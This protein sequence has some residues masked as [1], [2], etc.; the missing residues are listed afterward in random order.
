MINVKELAKAVKGTITHG[1]LDVNISYVS[2]NSKD[3]EAGALFVP[4]IGQ[5]HDG[6]DFIEDAYKHGALACFS[7]KDEVYNEGIVVIKVADTLKALQ[8]FATY[9]RNKFDI[10]IVGITGSVGKTTTKE[11]IS[12]AL[13]TKYN[14]LK[15]A[16]NMN[17][18]VGLPLMIL[19]IRE[20]HDIGV[21]EMGI[22]EEGEMDRL[23]SIVKPD[24]SVITNIGVSHIGQLKTKENIRR[25]KLC[26]I[27]NSNDSFL[28]IN[29]DDP[30][31]QEVKN[32][33]SSQNF[34][35]IYLSET[36]KSKTKSLKI[37]TYGINGV[38]DY[39]AQNIKVIDDKT[40]FT[41]IDSISGIQEEVVLNVLGEHNISNALCALAIAKHY[42]IPPSIAKKGLEAYKPL[43]MR[44]DIKKGKGLT[45]IDDTYNASPD[46]MKAGIDILLSLDN[47]NRRIAVLADVLELGDISKESHLGV[48]KY[49]SQR[50][51]DELITIGKDA[52]YIAKGVSDN[53]KELITHS[54]DNNI[55][56]INYLS[57]IVKA[58]DALLVKGSRGMKT[59][60][61]VKALL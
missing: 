14:V 11:M 51:V 26:I 7:S 16:G 17:S 2:T 18:Q 50:N 23:S 37:I 19:R 12:A 44:G 55:E 41:F 1:S 52:K 15:T 35:N 58:G 34:A 30:L 59:E 22:S 60:E 27:N 20:E 40:H 42:K 56:A 5:L 29:G 32:N 28:F 53:N 9:Y 31:L 25:E 47:I 21:I 54:F 4:I 43:H 8:D 24:L 45:I 49:I 10:P 48:G 36:T 3:L 46:S 38:C 33:K 6:H 61:I 39:R 13:S 57:K